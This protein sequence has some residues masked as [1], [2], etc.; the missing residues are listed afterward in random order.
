MQFKKKMIY[1]GIVSVAALIA[2][3]F[4][5][6]IPCRTAPLIPNPILKWTLCSLNLDVVSTGS[7]KEFF[8]YTN[9]L[10]EAYVITLIIAF[11]VSMIFFHY[12]TKNKKH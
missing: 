5:P 10:T 6:I 12:T 2:T 1:S 9:S 4:L 8:G 11:L 3:I 7:I